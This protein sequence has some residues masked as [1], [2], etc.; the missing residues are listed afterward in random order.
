MV[1]W[2]SNKKELFK[3]FPAGCWDVAWNIHITDFVNFLQKCQLWYA[4]VQRKIHFMQNKFYHDNQHHKLSR[5][6]FKFRGS[7][8]FVPLVR[9][10]LQ[11]VTLKN[12]ALMGKTLMNFHCC[13]WRPPQYLLLLLYI[14][15]DSRFFS[16]PVVFFHPGRNFV[17]AALF[18]Q[19][20]S[21]QGDV[22]ESQSKHWRRCDKYYIS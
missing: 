3:N 22:H 7:N 4:V 17:H 12:L 20:H 19:L 6:R 18:L 5:I 15:D 2:L 9:C 13:S 14:D 8:F 1:N 11:K 16:A 10:I 21:K